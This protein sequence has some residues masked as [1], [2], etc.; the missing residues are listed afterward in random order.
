MSMLEIQLV[1]G[2]DVTVSWLLN[3]ITKVQSFIKTFLSYLSALYEQFI[4]GTWLQNDLLSQLIVLLL[5]F[6]DGY[7]CQRADTL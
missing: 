4:K 7:R 3:L 2:T 5:W 6:L 1:F